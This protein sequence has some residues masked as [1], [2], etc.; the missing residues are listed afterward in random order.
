MSTIRVRPCFR[1]SFISFRRC[2][3]NVKAATQKCIL[4]YYSEIGSV[5]GLT[6]SLF[7]RN[8]GREFSAPGSYFKK[9]F[10]YQRLRYLPRRLD[11]PLSLITSPYLV[12]GHACRRAGN[13]FCLSR[14]SLFPPL[15][16]Q[17]HTRGPV[18]GP[19]VYPFCMPPSRQPRGKSM[20]S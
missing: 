16:P 6:M 19:R 13:L 7:R 2:R 17:L 18:R 4:H 9:P 10:D 1:P 12:W 3:F 8:T 15:R 11:P 14:L 20:V 5:R